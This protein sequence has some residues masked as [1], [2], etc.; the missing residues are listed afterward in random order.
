MQLDNRTRRVSLDILTTMQGTILS[1]R[2]LIAEEIG[3]GGMG[4][5]YRAT[6]L[7]TG[8]A[9]AVKVPHSFLARNTD[10]MERLRREAQIA[11][12]VYSPRV[13][14]VV[15]FY[16]HEGVP[17][18]VMEYVPGE[19]LAAVARQQGRFAL[20]ETLALGLEV[21]R[22]LEAAHAKGVIHRD[23]KPQ[24]IKLVEGEVKVLDFGIAKGEGFANVTAASVFMGTPEYCAPE[25]GA[26]EGD[27]RSDIYSLGVILFEM[28]EGQLPFQAAT[29]LALMKQHET[30]PAPPLTGDVPEAFAAIIARCLAKDPAD[31][32]QT[33]RELVQALR[34]VADLPSGTIP[35]E[36]STEGPARTIIQ[37]RLTDS[38]EVTQAAVA[39]DAEPLTDSGAVAAS[40]TVAVEPEPKA[41]AHKKRLLPIVG[42]VAAVLIGGAIAAFV[43]LN[44]DDGDDTQANAGAVAN[45]AVAT[46]TAGAP[47]T[48]TAQGSG[49][50]SIGPPLLAPGEEKQLVNTGRVEFDLTSNGCPGV[51]TI[52][53]PRTIK[54]EASGRVV[55][56]YT[57]EV[58]RIEGVE[59]VV[60]YGNDATSGVM[61]L[62][63][64]SAT[65]RTSQAR[66][67]GGSGVS[68]TGAQDIY[69]Q[70]PV[71]GEWWWDRGVDLNGDELTLLR[72]PQGSEVPLFRLPLLRQ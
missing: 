46:V 5:V 25:R 11:A 27:I 60:D 65:G 13:V 63:T 52:L 67:T 54:A 2:Y 51:K 22:A 59:C 71:R 69:G 42:I 26:G 36:V 40:T 3:I 4:S 32:Y 57:V 66:N 38:G 48:P 31:R 30:A 24:N 28:H 35:T 43:L 49:D 6:D 47:A 70:E 33:P 9:V 1:N 39:A 10:Y 68:V 44:R 18:L 16:E 45:G 53:Q 50:T 37:P 7:R 17:Y 64:R 56:S 21:A 23:L 55:V 29:P 12:S 62:Q 8:G 19:T 15:D 34:A 61:V 41:P 20:A 72:V 14:R 58:P